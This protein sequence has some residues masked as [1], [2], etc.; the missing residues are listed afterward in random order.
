MLL[1]LGVIVVMTL[2]KQFKKIQV[3]L[4]SIV[5]SILYITLFYSHCEGKTVHAIFVCMMTQKLA[6]NKDAPLHSGKML[7]KLTCD[8]NLH[9]Q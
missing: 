1:S 5:S 3:T 7:E 2:N 4:T 8:M 9:K 6:N